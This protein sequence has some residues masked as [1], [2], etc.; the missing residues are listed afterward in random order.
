MSKAWQGVE[1]RRGRCF[2]PLPAVPPAAEGLPMADQRPPSPTRGEGSFFT[3]ADGVVV[4]RQN[5]SFPSRSE[6]IEGQL[7]ESEAFAG[8]RP[9]AAKRRHAGGR[10]V[11]KG[12]NL[13]AQ[14]RSA[15]AFAAAQLRRGEFG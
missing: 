6:G 5:L 1:T 3:L 2:S 4:D 11:W 8:P 7:C 10:G 14:E 13:P 15:P 9:A 12:E